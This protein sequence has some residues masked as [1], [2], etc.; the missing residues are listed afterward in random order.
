AKTGI[1]GNQGTQGGALASCGD[2][3]GL[4]ADTA[5]RVEV[6]KAALH[7]IEPQRLLKAVCGRLSVGKS[8]L[9][10]CAALVGA[11]M[12][13]ASHAAFPC[14]A[15]LNAIRASRVPIESTH[16]KCSGL[17]G[18]SRAGGFNRLCAFTSLRPS[19]LQRRLAAPI[20]TR[21]SPW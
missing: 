11:A 14:A 3:N 13:P 15:G 4:N 19:Q 16:S 5:N 12:C 17:G 9:R 2:S 7:P 20:P 8:F 21:P 1:T 10:F 18:F 6:S